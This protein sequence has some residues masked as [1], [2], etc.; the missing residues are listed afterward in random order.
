[1]EFG[2]SSALDP[3]GELKESLKRLKVENIKKKIAEI[4][5]D[6]KAAEKNGD[7]GK[8]KELMGEF[9]NLASMLGQIS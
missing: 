3:A 7:K 5:Q 1:V 4:A 9:Q 6:I 8:V 2:G